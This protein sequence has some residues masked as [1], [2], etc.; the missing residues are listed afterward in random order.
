[1]IIA[2]VPFE[3][4][5]LTRDRN[6]VSSKFVQEWE[7]FELYSSKCDCSSLDYHRHCSVFHV[8]C[9]ILRAFPFREIAILVSRESLNSSTKFQMIMIV[10]NWRIEK[11]QEVATDY[12]HFVVFHIISLIFI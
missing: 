4:F 7:L 2:I 11:L 1:M 6:F 3:S 5:F 12:R 8:V 9:F 10:S